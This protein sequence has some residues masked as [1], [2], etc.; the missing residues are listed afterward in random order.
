MKKTNVTSEAIRRLQKDG[1]YRFPGLSRS[2][3][4]TAATELALKAMREDHKRGFE[5]NFGIAMDAFG[6][7]FAA[8]I[9]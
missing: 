9:N 8:Q 6:Y 1:E 7:Y 4:K 5:S 2:E 3:S